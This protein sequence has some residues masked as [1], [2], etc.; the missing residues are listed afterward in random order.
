MNMN[1]KYIAA[2]FLLTGAGLLSSCQDDFAEINSDPSTINNPNI[3]FLFTQFETAFQPADYSQWFY[4]FEYLSSW[5]QTTTNR[6]GNDNKI[7]IVNG[8]GCGYQVNEALRYANEI[9]NKISLLTGEEKEKYEYIQY[10][11]NPILVFLSMEDADMYGS[12]QYSEAEMVRYGGTLTP[13]YDTQEELFEIWLKQLEETLNYLAEK[14]PTDILSAQDFLYKGDLTKWAKFTNSLK[15]KIATRLINKDKARALQIVNEAASNPAG[16]VLTREDDIVINKGKRNNNFNNNLDGLGAGSQQFINFMIEN[17]DPR[18]FYFFMK[19]DY[20]ANV[21]QGFFDQERALPSYVEKNVEY[22]TENGKKVFTGWK[23]PG[24]P[25]V[26]F[27]GTPTQIDLNKN[28]EY[29]EYFDPNSVIFSLYDEKGVKKSYTPIA[30]RNKES[31]KG[32]FTYTYPDVPGVTP[33]QDTEPHGWYG[34]YFSA[35]EVNLLL[36]EFKLLGA[37]LP[38]SAQEYLTNGVEM[39]VRSYDFVAG[40]NHLPYYDTPYANDPYDKTIKLTEDQ[41]SEMLTKD[42]YKLTGNLTEDLEKVYI[43]Q[44]IHYFMLPMDMFVTARR[45]GVPMKNSELLPLKPFDP[46]MGDSYI[47]PR[48]F[49]VSAPDKSDLLYQITID[50][51]KAQG[52]TYEGEQYNTPS[53]LSNERVWY[54]KDAPVLGAGPKL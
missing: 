25:W 5:I 26:R 14:K 40:Q 49:P 37:N 27:Y 51:Y 17:R 3:R 11:C 19:N 20:N 39:S 21:V 35:G 46:V 9:R 22:K 47:I 38:K 32:G 30:Y 24:E 42:V 33:V 6:G 43:Q 50:A 10:L 18:M 28:P 2:I 31:I 12:R 48:R 52:Y 45:S 13:K 1:Y 41:V 54:D 4:G 23:A 36:A 16:L 7:N 34:L 44:I 53:T 29:D 8:T 15:L